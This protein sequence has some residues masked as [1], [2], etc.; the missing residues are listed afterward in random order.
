MKYLQSFN[1]NRDSDYYQEI[2]INGQRIEN[3]ITTHILLKQPEVFNRRSPEH[4]IIENFL[5]ENGVDIDS[6]DYIYTVHRN[7]IN[8]QFRKTRNTIRYDFDIYKIPDEYYMVLF[9]HHYRLYKCDQMDGLL[10]L[11]KDKILR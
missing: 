2:G 3:V 1:E 8:I 10:K 4:D 11:I 5:L 7:R 9:K 6:N